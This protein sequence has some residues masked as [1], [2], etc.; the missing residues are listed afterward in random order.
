VLH[1][2]FNRAALRGT[3]PPL[4][5]QWGRE[6]SAVLSPGLVIHLL[7]VWD[8]LASAVEDAAKDDRIGK[9]GEKGGDRGSDK[10]GD[11]GGDKGVDGVPAGKFKGVGTD[12]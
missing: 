7:Q 4:L 1:E 6:H 9:A 12:G 8:R 5:R 3:Y 10:A 11:K 2:I